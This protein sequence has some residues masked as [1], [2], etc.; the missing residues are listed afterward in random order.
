M[1][2]LRDLEGVHLYDR[3]RLLEEGIENI[4]NLAHHNRIELIARTR[5][6]T[7]RLVD[8]FDQAVL[9]L[10]LG[11][12]EKKNKE[13]YTMLKSHGI[14]TAT[15][16]DFA[17]G[18]QSA[19]TSLKKIEPPLPIEQMEVIFQTMLDDDWYQY[20]VQ[21]RHSSG[22][23]KPVITDPY[24]FY[25]PGRAMAPAPEESAT[26]PASADAAPQPAG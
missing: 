15:D 7:S 6:P 26:Q 22:T 12:H 24:Q 5:I 1:L 8:M 19:Y 11:L 23:R 25:F 21:W 18:T 9:Y 16:L 4:E 13:F 17:L 2:A 14:R 3:A 10:H 20:I